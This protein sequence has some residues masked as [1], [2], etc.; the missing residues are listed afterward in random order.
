MRDLVIL[1]VLVVGCVWT[2]RAP[3]IGTLMWVVTSIGSPHVGIGYAAATWPV[4]MLVGGCTLVGLLITKERQNPFK[5]SAVIATLVLALWM[6]LTLPFALEPELSYE[7]W[8]R[9]FKIFLMLFVCIALI[10]TQKKL[11]AFVWA[12]VMAIAYYGIKGGVFSLATGGHFMIIGPGGFIGG[13]NELALAE[14]VILPLMRYLQLQATTKWMRWTL[15]VCMGLIAISAIVSHSRGALL[16]LLAMV[17]FFWLKSGNKFRWA[18][19]IGVAA[20]VGLGAMPDE[21]WSRMD[22]IKTYDEDT[23]AQGRI[24]SWWTAYNIAND[25]IMGG[26]YR[27]TVNW[28]FAKYAPNPR[29]IFVAHS[30]YFQ[31]MGEQGYIGLLL[32]LNVGAL[33]WLNARRMIRLAKRDPT[34]KWAADL[35]AMIQVSMVGYAVTGAFLSMAYF[36]LPYNVMAMSAL[37]LAFVK[38]K[39]KA[40]PVAAALAATQTAVSGRPARLPPPRSPQ[41]PPSRPPFRPPQGP[42]RQT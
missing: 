40:A 32:F 23:S 36:D 4:G 35:G 26:G 29:V 21:W 11:H 2:L 7:G 16:G 31:M 9:S 18:L 22:T 28:I 27:L 3:W 33:T 20:V 39:P 6:S 41:R 1:I 38:L 19:I 10:D 37:G 30:I 34:L 42:P 5:N 24:N 8:E 14:I 17:G 12:N 25:R 13:N 15:G